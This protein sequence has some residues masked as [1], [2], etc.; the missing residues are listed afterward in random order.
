MVR[1]VPTKKTVS[2]EGLA[3]LYRDNVWKDFGLPCKIISDRG[4]QFVSH[5]TRALN[6]LLGISE[7]TSTAFR[8]Q[9]DGQTERANQ[10]VEIYLRAFVNKKQ[11]DWSEWL[12]CAEFALNNK[13]SST[14][15]YSPFFVNYGKNPRR[16]LAPIREPRSHVPHANAFAKQMQALHNEVTAA[17]DIAAESMRRSYDKHRRPAPVLDPGSLVLLDA[18]HID[19]KRASRKLSDRRVGPF[20]ILDRLSPKLYRLALPPSWRHSTV[21]NIERLVPFREPSFPSQQLSTSDT[22]SIEPAAVQSV[23]LH[24][25]LRTKLDL[26]VTL[27]GHSQED[28]FW[29]DAALL[30]DPDGVISRYKSLHSL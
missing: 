9:T 14:T 11:N 1:V 6:S 13:I 5:F 15:G 28:A 19:Q 20:T 7:N 30:H 16:P 22:L 3:R 17:L 26:L 27:V 4:P 29:E 18:K 2:S 25:S 24:R 21:F 12:A 23:L 8:P 10:E